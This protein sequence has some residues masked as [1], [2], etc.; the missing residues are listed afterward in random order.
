[1]LLQF[2]Q[3]SV[4]HGQQVLFENLNFTWNE[5]EHWAIIGDQGQELTDFLQLLLGNRSVVSGKIERP[6]VRTYALDKGSLGEVFSFRDLIAYV[7]QEYPFRNKS[8]LQNFYYQQRFNSMDSEDT[9]SVEDYL[10]NTPKRSGY[11]TLSHVIQL[12]RLEHLQKESLIKLS[13]GESRRLAIASALMQQPKLLL[14]DHPMTGLDV[15]TRASFNQILQAIQAAGV[16]ILMSTIPSE[17]P[18]SL[19]HIA[20]LKDRFLEVVDRKFIQRISFKKEDPY[21]LLTKEKL[22]DL[23]EP[24]NYAPVQ[25]L[26]RLEKVS[27]RYGEKWI[28]REL[29][30]EVKPGERW[31]LKGPN[32][33]G[34]STLISLLIGEHPQAY[35]NHIVLFDR[36]RGTGESIWEVKKPTGFVAP[37]LSRFFPRNQTVW[38]VLLSGF[39]DTMGLFKKSNPEQELKASQWLGFLKLNSKAHIPFQQLPLADQRILLL[40]RALIKSPQLLIVDEGAQGLDIEQRTRFKFLL[41]AVLE[42]SSV[43]LIYVSHYE[44]DIPRGVT[45]ILELKPS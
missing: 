16:H 38:K 1:M 6:F 42:L 25:S 23:F 19:T 41:E 10:K 26:V 17:I 45:K 31:L 12:L 20:M 40:A 15:Q 5:R 13:N 33:S 9:V 8:N 29:S 37:E 11:W 34:K 3:V 28:L 2:H 36:K 43:G 27:V 24:K 21:P 4:H 44:E 39:Y 18:E 32:G 22:R 30:W 14:M 35:A 7:G